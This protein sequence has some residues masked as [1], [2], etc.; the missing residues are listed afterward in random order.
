MNIS[1]ILTTDKGLKAC[2]LPETMLIELVKAI[3]D[4]GTEQV[5][6][7]SG[8]YYQVN[9]IYIPGKGNKSAI[10]VLP[11]VVEVENENISN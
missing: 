5:V 7:S 3:K 11:N 6:L 10:M 8:E 2:L 4:K 9:G 1:M